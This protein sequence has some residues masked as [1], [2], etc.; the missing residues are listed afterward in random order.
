[1]DKYLKFLRDKIKLASF[2]GFDTDPADIHPTLYP[3]QRDI[4]R[5]AVK[6]GNRAIFASF[7]LGKSVMQIEW[8]RQI[9]RMAGGQVLIVCPLGVRQELIR[10]G[11]MLGVEFR[12][13]R[14][15]AEIDPGHAFYMT[16]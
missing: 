1:M 12:F 5:W 4:A 16:N 14:S 7:G 6:G 2:S 15:A 10:D 8:C 3:H 13:I 9:Q 11:R